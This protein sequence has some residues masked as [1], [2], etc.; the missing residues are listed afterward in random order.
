M[1]FIQLVLLFT[2]TAWGLCAQQKPDQL[3]HNDRAA[4]GSAPVTFNPEWG[5]FYH[6]VAS[7]DPLHDRVII[8]TRV[9]PDNHDG[10]SVEV[11]WRMATD[12]AM[13]NVVQSGIF[14]TNES[15]DY[16]V[17]I[18]VMSLSAGTTY[19][20]EFEALGRTSLVGKTKTTPAGTQAA[21]LKFGVVSCSNY[22]AGYFN[23][24][25]RLA[26]RNDLDAVIHLG[27]Y[28]YEYGNGTY[29]DS[30][31]AL[32]RPLEPPTEII[33]LE[34]Y[35][36][37]YSTYRLDTSL[38]RVHQQ[39][40]FIT[41]WDDHESANDSYVAGAQNHNE[42]EG[43]W[44]VRKVISKQV[45]FEW[46]P[47][48]DNDDFQVYRKISYGDLLDLIML[49][50][51]LEGREKQV[52]SITDPDLNDPDRTILGAE[53][54]AWL[55]EQLR[56]ST[57]RWKV[58]GQ[59]VMFAEFN[60]GW[61]ALGDPNFTFEA[62]ES[63]FL[64]IWDGYPAERTQILNFIQENNV[65]NVVIL[66][67]DVHSAFAFDVADDPVN[68][69]FQTLPVVGR[70]PLYQPTPNYD[71]TTGAGAVAVEF[72]TPSV[73]S[74][75]FDENL[76]LEAAQGFQAQ[77]NTPIEPVPGLVNL[78][79]PNPHMK[80]A[81]LIQHGYFIL[82][83]K[84]DS[85]QANWYYSPIL[86]VAQEEAFGSAWYTYAGE[87]RLRNAAT[88]SAPKALQDTPAP[89]APLNT[90][91]TKTT[92]RQHKFAVLGVYPNPFEDINTLHY[93][94][95]EAAQVQ[96]SLYDVKGKLVRTLLNQRMQPGIFSLQLQANGLPKGAYVYQIQVDDQRYTAK[97]V[98]S[99]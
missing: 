91:N 16:T 73:T 95:A 29:G 35:R 90:T 28:I 87:S 30:A 48:R 51:R 72:V 6:G 75:N 58:I 65:D 77:I 96:I 94:L 50:T 93:S 60:V 61:A 17:K 42:D 79:N 47:I 24:Y 27:D 99:K 13:Q 82:D 21:H 70:V 71:A 26:E 9:T 84:A 11:T 22:Q 10:T 66:T 31:V 53:Q 45:Y 33:S 74:A 57:A 18:D 4:F 41:V 63:I 8:W 34:D 12:A 39:H 3:L 19:Y 20:Y 52:Q 64:D 92:A 7:G 81:D 2:C 59:Q 62:L 49:D 5:P 36:T 46:M 97:V 54:K 86:T 83:V 23:G 40:P 32:N 44:D 56:N 43:E 80:Y 98:L 55:L 85:T 1:K 88:P 78:G 68:V 15:R 38:I 76:N 14:T 37:R 25:Q 67:G 69:T 89:A